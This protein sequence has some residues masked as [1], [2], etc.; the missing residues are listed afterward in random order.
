MFLSTFVSDR[1]NTYLTLLGLLGGLNE[2][3][4]KYLA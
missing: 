3:N 4:V 2:Q 1:N